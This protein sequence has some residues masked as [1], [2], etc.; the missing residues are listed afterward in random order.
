[1]STAQENCF[2]H[3]KYLL[4]EWFL[5][6]IWNIGLL[7]CKGYVKE[8]PIC[9]DQIAKKRCPKKAGMRLKHVRKKNNEKCKGGCEKNTAALTYR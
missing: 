9:F 5:W 6:N 7:S 1:V 3:V 4:R 8:K 2:G